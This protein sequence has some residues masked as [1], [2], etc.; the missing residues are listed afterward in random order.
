[1]HDSVVWQLQLLP[2]NYQLART[3]QSLDAVD[4]DRIGECFING[5]SLEEVITLTNEMVEL[6][7]KGRAIAETLPIKTEK[8]RLELSV[9]KALEILFEGGR[10]VLKFYKYRDLLGKNIDPKVQLEKMRE[11]VLR[12]IEQSTEMIDVW[13]NDTRLGYH[14]EAEAYKFFPEKLE[15]RIAQLKNLLETEFVEVEKRIEDGLYPLEYYLGVDDGTKRHEMKKGG[16]E[17]SEWTYFDDD[18]SKFRMSYDDEKIYLELVSPNVSTFHINPEFKM[19]TPGPTLFLK[20]DSKP[21][22][23]SQSRYQ[24]YFGEYGDIELAKWTCTDVEDD[25]NKTHLIVTFNHKESEWEG[26]P[27]KFC[28]N[29]IH[30]ENGDRRIP[31]SKSQIYSPRLGR[32]IWATDELGWIIPEK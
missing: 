25:D 9:I 8:Q 4:G 26:R 24:G 13:N 2:K 10:D 6:W 3:W 21:A 31:W 14:S 27:F 32:Y 30:T 28:A 15:H 16:L 23:S 7:K 19:M 18:F 20:K 17:N 12:G 1:M 29:V 11:I 22:L 5:H